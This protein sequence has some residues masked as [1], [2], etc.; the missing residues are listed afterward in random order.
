MKIFTLALATGLGISASTVGLSIV[1]QDPEHTVIS[2]QEINWLPGPPS[3]PK[4]A[5]IAI[6]QGDI[7]A[8][9]PFTLRVKFPANY[10]VP[11]HFHPEDE[12]LTVISGSLEVGFGDIFLVSELISLPAGGFTFLPAKHAHFVRTKAETVVQINA[13]GPWGITYINPLDDPGTEQK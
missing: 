1:A 8:A 2:P 9:A 4:G 11:P 5:Q 13:M 3:L 10:S 7:G 6:L 12:A